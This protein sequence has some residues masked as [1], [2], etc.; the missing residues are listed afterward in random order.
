MKTPPVPSTVAPGNLDPA[1]AVA[2]LA[3]QR[4]VEI[5]PLGELRVFEK[6]LSEGKNYVLLT[7]AGALYANSRPLLQYATPLSE[8]SL[9][10]LQ[11]CGTEALAS[12]AAAVET[13]SPDLAVAAAD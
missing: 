6:R 9:A 1:V 3:A 8:R 2:G 12:S 7:T 11:R 10:L 13:V 5:A 4:Y